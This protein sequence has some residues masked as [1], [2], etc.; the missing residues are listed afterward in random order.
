MIK[1]SKIENTVYGLISNY[2]DYENEGSISLLNTQFINN[3][4]HIFLSH[5][6]NVS[7]KGCSFI[8]APTG[9]KM[10]LDLCKSV[11]MIYNTFSQNA[12]ALSL[13][14]GYFPNHFPITV[15][16]KIVY[17]NFI[18]NEMNLSSNCSAYPY[19]YR[20]YVPNNYWDAKT[21]VGVNSKIE[22]ED[23]I[24]RQPFFT[25][26]VLL[27]GPTLMSKM[28]DVKLSTTYKAIS[29]VSNY[30][31]DSTF[32]YPL[33]FTVFTNRS[34][35]TAGIS[36][37]NI[38]TIHQFEFFSDT[39]S[40]IV[41]AENIF[42]Q[43]QTDTFSLSSIVF[44]KVILMKPEN[45]SAIAENEARLNWK[46]VIGARKYHLQ[47]ASDNSM[48]Y[49]LF[50]D[51]TITADSL[52]IPKLP[53]NKN[54]FW[55]VK[56]IGDSCTGFWSD[57]WSFSTGEVSAISEDRTPLSY[58][59]LQNYPNPFNSSTMIRFALPTNS[60]VSIKIFNSL[61]KEIITL[62]DEAKS[63]GYYNIQFNAVNNPSGIYYCRMK[64][65]NFIDTRKI[66]LLK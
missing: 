39:T 6:E 38:L 8:G 23:S 16:P 9:V 66:L 58:S 62:M 44:P 35:L 61:G 21:I 28:P 51:S 48:K 12:N 54:F 41:N 33:T 45:G 34:D 65:E 11:E 25:E 42:H 40:I 7:F 50:N 2:G 30:F 37:T 59:L 46:R 36:S 32:A 63:A 20:L 1:D 22:G 43:T 13:N 64:A 17:N 10:Y 27:S 53:L 4:E 52:V 60:H 49:L 19:R 18:N 55:R 47:V 31:S 15:V 26:P 14:V 57:L 56:A 29:D 5:T 24:I 3:R